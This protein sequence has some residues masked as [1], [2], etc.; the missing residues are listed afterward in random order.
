MGTS[1]NMH[2]DCWNGNSTHKHLH[3]TEE[4]HHGKQN[5]V[6]AINALPAHSIARGL[7]HKS[8]GEDFPPPCN[9]FP[10]FV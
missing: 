9:V 6:T 3:Y 10:H 8:K 1:A 5:Q 4:V 7:T 2:D